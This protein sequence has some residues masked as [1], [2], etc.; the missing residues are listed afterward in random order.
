MGGNDSEA[1]VVII[2][3]LIILGIGRHK[4]NMQFR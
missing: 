4:E 2:I 1:P 3:H